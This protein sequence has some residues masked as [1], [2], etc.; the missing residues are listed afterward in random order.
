MT[1]VEGVGWVLLHFVWQGALIAL[2]LAIALAVTGERQARLRYALD[3]RGVDADAGGDAG[4]RGDGVDER[5]T[6][7]RGCRARLPGCFRHE[8]SRRL[9]AAGPGGVAPAAAAA[10]ASSLRG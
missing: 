8:R 2:A 5:V 4:D 10:S 6:L 9:F 3:V 1:I 7:Q